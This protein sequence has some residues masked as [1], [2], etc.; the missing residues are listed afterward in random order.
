MELLLKSCTQHVGR[1]R[2]CSC[3]QTGKICC[4]CLMRKS[5]HLQDKLQYFSIKSYVVGVNKNRI[6]DANCY[7]QHIIL[8]RTDDNQEQ[9]PLISWF[10]FKALYVRTRSCN[11][12][13]AFISLSPFEKP[14]NDKLRSTVVPLLAVLINF[15]RINHYVNVSVL[16]IF[17]QK[18][19]VLT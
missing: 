18:T 8:W 19:S 1:R 15:T 7:P 2:R 4:W 6:P 10:P 12:V 16:I 17:S 5:D 13:P 9:N 11:A 3:G 14:E